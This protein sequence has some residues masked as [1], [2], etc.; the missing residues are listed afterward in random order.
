MYFPLKI[1]R[2][3]NVTFPL[4]TNKEH[5]TNAHITV[6]DSIMAGKTRE[7][8]GDFYKDVI[9][10][11]FKSLGIENQTYFETIDKKSVEKFATNFI[12]KTS[13]KLQAIQRHI[14]IFLSGDT[15]ISEF[16]NNLEIPS[17]CGIQHIDIL[18]LPLGTAN[19]W[20]SIVNPEYSTM[21]L[22]RFKLASETIL[23]EY[24]LNVHLKVSTD[25]DSKVIDDGFAYF[26]FLN[27]SNLE[28]NYKPSPLS[29]PFEQSLN[30]LGY[31]SKLTKDKLV[32]AIMKGYNPDSQAIVDYYRETD[33]VIYKKFNSNIT[34]E[35]DEVFE[36]I[37]E[38][39]KSQ[40]CIDGYLFDYKDLNSSETPYKI[41][42]RNNDYPWK[43]IVKVF[44]SIKE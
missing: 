43:H 15:T 4:L 22:E 36:P 18:P 5:L 31:T 38:N 30:L 7:K 37:G 39:L 29:K 28:P 25:Q 35:I 3:D 21:G 33:G 44:T 8:R 34:I 41:T 40:I 11:I 42:I 23:K 19:A 27:Q 24:D 6:V 32:E 2:D 10:P 9:K 14:V 26:A 13:T 17:Q 1:L 12:Q 20:S 16:L